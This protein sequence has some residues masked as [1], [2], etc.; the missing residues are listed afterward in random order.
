M[1]ESV[2]IRLNRLL[3]HGEYYS[4]G[5]TQI[6]KIDVRVI[7]ASIHDLMSDMFSDVMFPDL[8]NHLI[9]HSIMIPP[10]R[11]RLDDLLL[12][13]E[14]SL[15]L[16]N[17]RTGKNIK[18]FSESFI[19]MLKKYHFPGNLQELQDIIATSVINTD[20]DLISI[21][22][23]SPYIRDKMLAEKSEMTEFK[24]R[25]L[26]DVVKE[27]I[28]KT[29]EFFSQDVIRAS[30]ELGISPDEIDSTLKN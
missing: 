1:P 17:K 10:L 3:Q 6:K 23:I 26:N 27:H 15:E 14:H 5:S 20:A 18:G 19:E 8:I 22:S 21:E 13:A 2:Q 7:A 30:E 16:E 29:L 9:L 11:K 25:K 24:P 28:M 4:E 12:I